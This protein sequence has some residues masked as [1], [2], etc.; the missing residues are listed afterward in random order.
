MSETFLAPQEISRAEWQGMPVFFTTEGDI[1]FDIFA[2][3]FYLLSRYEEYLPHENDQYGRYAH[4]NSIA[5]RFDFLKRPLINEWMMALQEMLKQKFP[6]IPVRNRAADFKFVPT[7]DIDEA[8]RYDHQ[9][10]WRN[11]FGFFR[12]FIRGDFAAVMER[13][14]AYT[15]TIPDP[16]DVF[17]WLDELHHAYSLKPIYFFLTLLKKGQYDKNLLSGNAGIRQ[18]YQKTAKQY[19]SRLHPSWQSGLEK[20]LLQ[21][22]RDVLAEITGQPVKR[23]RNHYL[24]FTLPESYRDLIG[25]DIEE[26]YSMAYGNANG[27]RASYAHP[28]KWYDLEREEETTLSLHPFCFMEACSRFNQGDSASEAGKE[29]QYFYNVVKSVGGE[30]VTLFHNHFLTTQPGWIEWRMMYAS[31]LEKNFGKN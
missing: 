10:V 1:P 5:Y 3:S 14:N 26:E 8:Y 15:G 31:F 2:A 19:D 20:G 12:D 4:T 21:K 6:Q 17:G 13:G 9:P 23:S 18:L 29:L 7:Y 11:V 30:L 27:F 28:F 16:Y 24:R 25:M 22:E